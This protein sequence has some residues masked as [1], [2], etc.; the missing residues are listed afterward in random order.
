VDESAARH[1]VEA[2]SGEEEIEF[3]TSYMGGEDEKESLYRS[4]RFLWRA[5]GFGQRIV[6]STNH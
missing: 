2:D 6:F 4:I 3:G 1:G 5:F